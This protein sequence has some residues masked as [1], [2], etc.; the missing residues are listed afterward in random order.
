MSLLDIA[1]MMRRH[2]IAMLALL[3]V[4]AASGFALVRA[5]PLYN[6]TTT[7][8]LKT[9]ANPFVEADSL[10]VTSDLMARSMMSPQSQQLVS[11]AGG[12][13]GYQ[14]SLVNLYNIEYPNY[15]DPYVTVSVTAANPVQVKN[16]Y[17][18]VMLVLARELGSWQSG[19]GIPSIDQIGLY[20]LS[21]TPGVVPLSGS[22]LRTLAGL[23][24][25]TVI[26]LYVLAAFLDRREI[27][28]PRLHGPGRWR[29]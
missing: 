17:N 2:A 19:N 11:E 6:D 28:V 10:L 23:L 18:A 27:W 22:A 8:D 15:S 1:S 4:I 24:V 14:V 26:G 12:T 9:T 13:V 29:L 3:V 25:L 5:A 16:T 20:V 21:G 7:V